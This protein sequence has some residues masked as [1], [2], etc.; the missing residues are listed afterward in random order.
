MR[1]FMPRLHR[2]VLVTP[3]LLSLACTIDIGASASDTSTS[4]DNTT[5]TGDPPDPTT[6]EPPGTTGPTPTTSDGTTTAE[7]TTSD[8]TTTGA[9][10]A[11]MLTGECDEGLVCWAPYDPD[12]MGPGEFTCQRAC[13]DDKGGGNAEDVWCADDE[14]CCDAGSMCGDDGYCTSPAPMTT[15]ETDTSGTDSSGTDTDGTD[16]SGTDTGD[17]SGS[18]GDTDTGGGVLPNIS[19]A[20]LEVTANCQPAVPPDPISAKWKV[21][22][23]NKLGMAEITAEVTGASLIFNP[24]NDE[25]V[26]GITVNPTSSGVVAAGKS[27]MV[28]MAK[29]KALVDLPMDCDQ[30]G[31]P[32]AVEV[33]FDV[34]GQ[35]IAATAETTMM[36]VF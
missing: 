12:S 31:K 34:D 32:V 13:V 24:G 5:T 28:T 26:Q 7:P 9:P 14:A 2:I 20:G 29:T 16:S 33:V 4:G 6:G 10:S 35:D 19:I 23:D 36:C 25:F 8:D 3:V 17:S 15:G 18:T 30:C 22:F 11:C 27:A 21:T 1:S